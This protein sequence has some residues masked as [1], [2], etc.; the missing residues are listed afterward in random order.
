MEEIQ[1]IPDGC[2]FINMILDNPVNPVDSSNIKD[3][4]IK[5]T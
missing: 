4:I 1:I 2:K 3:T 5:L